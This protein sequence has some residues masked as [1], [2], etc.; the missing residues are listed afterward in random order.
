MAAA[1]PQNLQWPGWGTEQL[2]PPCC[3]Y[4]KYS[5]RASTPSPIR[6]ALEAQVAGEER[7]YHH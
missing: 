7:P 3:L 2:G 5:G 4:L 1:I 6:E